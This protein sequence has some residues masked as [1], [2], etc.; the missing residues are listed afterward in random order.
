[1]VALKNAAVVEALADCIVPEV[2]PVGES[3]SNG[4]VEAAINMVKGVVRSMK[5][6]LQTRY[7]MVLP[8]NHPVVPWLIAEA[9][10]NI[11][12]YQTKTYVSGQPLLQC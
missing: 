8:E 10:N 2:S 6:S 3:Q 9:A 11:N 1:M 5:L 4:K 7:N 12:R